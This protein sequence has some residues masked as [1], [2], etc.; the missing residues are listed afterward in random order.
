VQRGEQGVERKGGVPDA[1]ERIGRERVEGGGHGGLGRFLTQGG[2]HEEK[3][4]A[5][6][7]G[8]GTHGAAEG[9]GVG[10][11]ERGVEDDEVGA[12]VGEDGAGVGER[13]GMEGE[14]VGVGDEDSPGV[15]AGGIGG[16]EQGGAIKHE[17]KIR[18]GA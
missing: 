10:G 3:G 16:H 6:E 14:G 7:A 5:G 8:M 13:G 1:C 11:G 12:K 18:R 4:D 15:A 17:G 2:P 9:A